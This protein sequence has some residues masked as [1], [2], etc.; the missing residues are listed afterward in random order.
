M[1][2]K[3]KDK[4]LQ[5]IVRVWAEELNCGALGKVGPEDGTKG[6]KWENAPVHLWESE[7]VDNALMSYGKGVYYP[8][9]LRNLLIHCFW[10]GTGPGC[11][12]TFQ[13]FEP[14]RGLP[15]EIM[16]LGYRTKRILAGAIS[17]FFDH[18]AME[19]AECPKPDPVK[20][21]ERGAA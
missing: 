10:H 11:H 12:T 8:S 5:R 18:L 2:A 9:Y 3:V 20:D 17:M 6:G 15:P 4:E 19:V 21:F 7:R 16:G 14:G 13:L 1:S